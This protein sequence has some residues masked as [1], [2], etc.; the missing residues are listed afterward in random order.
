MDDFNIIELFFQRSEKAV[1]ETQ[2]KI[3]G[4]YK[5]CGFQHYGKNRRCTRM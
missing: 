3:R 1:A 5:G 4:V 2:K